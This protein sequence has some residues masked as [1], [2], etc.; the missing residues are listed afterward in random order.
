MFNFNVT[1][2]ITDNKGFTSTSTTVQVGADEAAAE[3]RLVDAWNALGPVVSDVA[4]L[5][6]LKVERA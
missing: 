3:A 4:T 1:A 6:V 2:Q 5:K